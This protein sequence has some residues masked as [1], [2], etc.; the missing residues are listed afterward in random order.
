MGDAPPTTDH[1]R[2]QC[3][4]QT[5][6]DLQ[7][8][9]HK[10]VQGF[11]DRIVTLCQEM[12][13][14][15]AAI[16]SVSTT[17]VSP[18]WLEPAPRV[19]L[20]PN[21][22]AGFTMPHD[23]HVAAVTQEA[24]TLS[25]ATEPSPPRLFEINDS[26]PDND[27]STLPATYAMVA[28]ARNAR[29]REILTPTS[30]LSTLPRHIESH[31]MTPGRLPSLCPATHPTSQTRHATTSHATQPT[32]HPTSQTRHAAT[33]H[34]T[35]SDLPRH[36]ATS[37]APT[38]SPPLS[39]TEELYLSDYYWHPSYSSQAATDT[40]SV[41]WMELSQ[42]GPY[43]G[44][45]DRLQNITTKLQD[46]SLTSFVQFYTFL[47][48]GLQSCSYHPHLLLLLDLLRPDTDLT[49]TPISALEVP[50]IGS[51]Q[52][53]TPTL[54][55]W[56]RRRDNLGMTLYALLLETIPSSAPRAQHIVRQGLQ[57]G[58]ANGFTALQGILCHVHPRLASCIAPTYDSI[59]QAPPVMT[60][61]LKLQQCPYELA[62][63]AYQA[64]HRDWI[65]QLSLYR[66]EY[67]IRAK[68]SDFLLKFLHTVVP[69]FKPYLLFSFENQLV[70][71]GQRTKYQQ[72]EPVIPVT[73]DADELNA[74]LL[75]AAQTFDNQ[76]WAY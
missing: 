1:D 59:L 57:L 41:N 71:F 55:Y 22:G 52:E 20:A 35:L 61:P 14:P 6:E 42:Q 18:V 33:S 64:A 46:D 2:T 70:R 34:A 44:K 51:Q 4:N 40:H 36:S 19:P 56:Q 43:A 76:V 69:E 72:P 75:C 11:N 54:P 45:T 12:I 16:D 58:S 47:R 32:S 63:V 27:E 23:L 65:H 60:K 49:V 38:K 10:M 39:L 9:F 25:P 26:D 48:A 24:P 13:S 5:L 74:I 68:P 21:R 53:Y 3:L 30:T 15:V 29:R 50:A 67:Q 73:F 8:S 28:A 7:D 62:L 17:D 31:A 66:P 37:L